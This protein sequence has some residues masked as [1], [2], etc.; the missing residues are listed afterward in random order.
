[1]D[2]EMEVW[3]LS[4][5]LIATGWVNQNLAQESTLVPILLQY[6]TGEPQVTETTKT[7]SRRATQCAGCFRKLQ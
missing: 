2:K 1:M 5:I 7:P 6:L 4:H 3:G